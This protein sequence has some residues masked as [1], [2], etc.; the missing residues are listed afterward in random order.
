[1][2]DS[3]P[4]IR[5]Q[6]PTETRL[7][8]RPWCRASAVHSC[9]LKSHMSRGVTMSKSQRPA[10]SDRDFAPTH[11]AIAVEA[12]VITLINVLE[13]APERQAELVEILEKAT[14]ETM[15]YFPGFISA[16]IHRS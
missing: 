6:S 12:P 8:S 9:E 14:A 11:A 4:S 16:S 15:R 10:V 5:R 13:V 7:P 2:R 3:M 1:M